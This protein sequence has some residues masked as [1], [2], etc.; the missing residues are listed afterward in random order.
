LLIVAARII[1]TNGDSIVL[2]NTLSV[3]VAIDAVVQ[4]AKYGR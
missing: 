1:W 2:T 4:F 3:G